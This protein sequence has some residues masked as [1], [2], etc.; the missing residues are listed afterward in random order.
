MMAHGLSFSNQR[1][2]NDDACI[3]NAVRRIEPVSCEGMSAV[4]ALCVPDSAACICAG[5][6]KQGASGIDVH[7]QN[8]A[9]VALPATYLGL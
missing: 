4:E 3:C 7:C 9:S 2:S 6:G 1:G 5:G 8:W